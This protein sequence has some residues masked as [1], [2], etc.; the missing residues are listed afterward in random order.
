MAEVWPQSG[1]VPIPTT[2][3]G[4]SGPTR[5]R[6]KLNAL[7]TPFDVSEDVGMVG[8]AVSS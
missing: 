5:H 1:C 7:L 6:V 3:M 4:L 2:E 8:V